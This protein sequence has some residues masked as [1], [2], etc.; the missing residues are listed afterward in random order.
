MGT[1]G[2]EVGVIG[3]SHEKEILLEAHFFSPLVRRQRKRGVDFVLF[4]TLVTLVNS[5]A[6]QFIKLMVVLSQ[7]FIVLK[8]T[9][10]G[11]FDL[12]LLDSPLYSLGFDDVA[13]NC[14]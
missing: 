8:I 9:N 1:H 6:T 7:Y 14:A 5:M 2:C 10:I 4:I 13:W 11:P 12:G 3:Q